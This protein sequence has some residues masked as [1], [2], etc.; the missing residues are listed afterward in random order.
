MNE[1]VNI[2]DLHGNIPEFNEN[3]PLISIIILSNNTTEYIDTLLNSLSDNTQYPNFE[4]ILIDNKSDV[5]IKDIKAKYDDTLRI[6]VVE[7]D[8]DKTYAHAYNDAVSLVDGDY[9]VFMDEDIQV[10]NGWLNYLVDTAMNM[11]SAGAVSSVLLYP[12]EDLSSTD[13]MI[14]NEGINFI[15]DDS[16]IIPQYKNNGQDYIQQVGIR[17]VPAVGGSLMLMKKSLFNDM[18]GFSTDY[19]DGFESVDLCLKLY[20]RGYKNFIDNRSIAFHS[21]DGSIRRLSEVLKKNQYNENKRVFTTKWNNWLKKEVLLD[22]IN[23]NKFFSDDD[24]KIVFVT[25][26]KG[27]NAKT[28]DYFVAQGLSKCLGDMGYEIDFIKTV[29]NEDKYLLDESIDVVISLVNS[30]DIDKIRT[31]NGLLIKVA[32]ILDWAMWWT[33]K[34]FFESFDIVLTTHRTA[35]E[36]IEETTGYLPTLFYEAVDTELFNMQAEPKE[37]YEC[38]YMFAGTDWNDDRDITELLDPSVIPY[39]FNIYGNKWE[40]YDKFNDYYKGY[41]NHEDMPSVYASTK[42]VLDDVTRQTQTDSAV[43]NRIYDAIATGS[44]VITNGDRGA[45]EVFGDKLPTFYDQDTLEQMLDYY[46]NNPDERKLIVE[47]LQSII[48]EKHTYKK[49]AE[50]FMEQLVKFINSTRVLI[51]LPTPKEANKFEWGDYHMARELHKEFNRRDT[52][53]KLQF[54]NDWKTN[55]DSFYDVVVLLRGVSFYEAKPTHYNILWNISHPNRISVGE[56]ERYDQVYIASDYW[57]EKINELVDVNV[58]SLLQCTNP[59]RFY[60]QENEKYKTDLLF[61]G[62]SRM[63][64]R[65]ILQDLLPTDYNLDVYG[66]DWDQ[67]I[68]DKYVKGTYIPNCKLNQAYSS[69]KVLLNDHW[70]DMKDKGFI[71]NRIFDA[72]ACGTVILTDH[73]RDIEKVFPDAVVVYDTQDELND[74]IR[75]ALDKKSVDPSLVREHTFAKRVEKILADYEENKDKK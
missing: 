57:A 44:L 64:Y 23:K 11:E 43:N 46:I 12:D 51:K 70:S 14:H 40:D 6:N 74:K 24:L 59:A 31:D 47:E 27:E 73:V 45:R 36:H 62:N 42:I 49:R 18:G 75:E 56:L 69:T 2:G 20:K 22:K 65:K 68:D 66:N 9:V 41:I 30:F 13:H 55:K 5:N 71:S 37:E 16:V 58:D 25:L 8:V 3:S 50:Q 48:L 1:E 10:R 53:C 21:E 29:N 7:Y 28:G 63:V 15:T 52:S 34:P 39:K 54:Y 33:N 35:L 72:I 61:V 4:V 60:R 67:I 19:R 32:W 17:E 38:D 26:E